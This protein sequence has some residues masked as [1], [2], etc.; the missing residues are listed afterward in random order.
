MPC[1][2]SCC[3][4]SG[5]IWNSDEVIKIMHRYPG[6]V[7]AFISG[8]DHDGGYAIDEGGIH[9][10]VLPAP[11]E[12][13]VDEVAYGHIEV[14]SSQSNPS[15]FELHWTG[16]VPSPALYTAWPTKMEFSCLT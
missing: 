1:Y 12:C 15:F 14:H 6:V 7:G 13:E 5:L 8:H 9:H 3:R 4:P 16:K 10:L 11:L 2:S